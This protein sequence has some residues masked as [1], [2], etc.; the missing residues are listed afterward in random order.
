DEIAELGH[1]FND[2][3]DSLAYTMQVLRGMEANARRFA[4]DVSHELRTPI[5]AITAVSGILAEDAADLPPDTGTAARLVAAQTR[6]L[7]T[8]VEDLLEISRMDAGTATLTLDEVPLETLVRECVTMRGWTDVVI[9]IP[10]D[11]RACVDP[12]RFDLIIANLIANAHIH[13]APPVHVT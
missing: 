8:L 7:T 12:R 10:P 13:G 2:S 11:L 1:T 6:R 9:E 3:A 4:A 5:A